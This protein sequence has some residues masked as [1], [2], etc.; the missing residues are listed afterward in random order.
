MF[1]ALIGQELPPIENYTPNVY[2]AGNQNWMISQASNKYIYVANNSGLLEFNGAN[3]KLYPFADGSITRSVLAIDNKIYTGSYMEFGYWVNDAYGDLKYTSLIEKFNTPLIVDEQFWNILKFNEWVLFQSLDRIYFYNTDDESFNIIDSKS[4]RAEIFILGNSIYF[5]K[6]NEGIFKIENGNSILVSNDPI[7]Q[8]N[9]VVGAFLINKNPF[10]VTENGRFYYL[11]E[12]G[13]TRWLIK[14]NEELSLKNVY[15]CLQ[16]KDG[17]FVL[18]TISNG[19]FHIDKEGKIISIINKDNGLNNNTVLSIFED[20]ENNLW[21][22]LDNGISVL[23]LK[24]PFIVYNDLKGILG[25][26]YTSKAFKNILYV[27]TNQGLFYKKLNTNNDF[28]LIMG[29]EGQVWCLKEIEDILFCGHN[30]GTYIINQNTAKQIADFPGTWDIKKIEK[31]KNLLLQG[32]YDGLSILQKVDNRWQFRNNIEG[33]EVSSRFFEFINNNQVL[34]NHDVKGIFTLDLDEDYNKILNQENEASHGQGS[35]LVTY[36]NAIIHSSNFSQEILKYDRENHMFTKDSVLTNNFYGENNNILGTLISDDDKLWGFSDRNIINISPG[37]FSEKPQELNIPVSTSFR[38]KIGVL[39]FENLA[40]LEGEM[41]LIGISNGY[42]ILNLDKLKP[43]E[44]AIKINS[45]NIEFT[46]SAPKKVLLTNSSEFKPKENNID[47]SF[48]V[49]EFDKFTDVE[50]QYQLIGIYD[51]WSLWFSEPHVS[52]NNLSFGDYTFN[53]K[54]R[55]GNKVTNNVASYSFKIER[56]LLLS[57][58]FIFLYVL[59]GIFISFLWHNIYKRYYIKQREKL[60]ESTAKEL[61]L[62]KLEN[63]QQLMRFK[64]EKL[65]QDIENKNRELAISTMSLIK[66]NEFLH[67]IKK[68]LKNTDEVKNLKYV[69]KI[70]DRNLNNT[71]DWQLFEE[72]FNN[73]DKDFLK[74]IKTDHPSLTSN[75]LRLCA[76]L[77]LNLSSKEIAP[78]LN[79]SARSVEVKRYRLR[80]KLGLSHESSLSDYILEI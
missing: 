7:I 48:S 22:G 54:A 60:L 43:K 59:M 15:S 57:N 40:Y 79:I 5:Q 19:I 70:I 53:V 4:T 20:V 23:N 25:T 68:D 30:N 77:R 55:V 18:G 39:G 28:K 29:T 13:L 37:K 45:I 64:N 44:Y 41:Y 51:E 47:F 21:L 10:F 31:D 3:W 9:T 35:S 27:G 33:F 12:N 56:P 78:L 2:N 34:V 58:V 46:N 24:S 1:N 71:D 74:K 38:R 32:N 50:Y 52:F 42:M 63:Q 16:L 11:N 17:G 14:A 65:R 73:A 67:N 66:K 6:I 75:D 69:I 76:Y 62:K 72:A 80:K 49:P 8:Q 36:N 61:E 26:V